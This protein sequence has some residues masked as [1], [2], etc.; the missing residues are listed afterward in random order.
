LEER[1]RLLRQR[2]AVDNQIAGIERAI[3]L[4]DD[5]F[6]TPV[7]RKRRTSTKS[8]VLD[9]LEDVGTT[10]LNASIAVELANRRGVSIERASVSS[11]LSRLKSDGIIEFDGERYRLKKYAPNPEPRT[12][13]DGL[14]VVGLGP[15]KS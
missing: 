9:L 2:E 7:A 12:N 14:N 15:R 13:L 10:G 6:V 5:E 11:L 8:V 4:C 1:D 3:A